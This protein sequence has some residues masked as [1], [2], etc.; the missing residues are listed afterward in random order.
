MATDDDELARTATAPASSSQPG[1]PAIPVDSTL[2]RYRIE[3]ELGAGGMGVVHAAFDPDLERRVALKVLRSDDGSGD[4]RQRLLR[5]ARAMA[6]LAHPNVVTVHEVGS[7][8]GRDFVAMELIDG[9]TLAD[10]LRGA[11]RPEDEIV[12]AFAAAARGLAAAHAAGIV[13]RD[14]KPHNVLRSRTGRIVVTDFGLARDAADVGA[15]PMAMTM[16]GTPKAKSG[17]TAS[18]SSPLSG[19]TATGSVLGTPAYMAPEQWSS[20]AV[21]P[22]TDQFAF[23]VAMWEAFTGERPFRSPTI[24][25]LKQEI[26]RGPAALDASK[27]PRR[28][29]AALIRGLDPEPKRR[30]PSMESLLAAMTKARRGPALAV[31][32]IGLAIV[33][34]AAIYVISRE[35]AAQSIA[36]A[37][38][39][40]PPPALDPDKLDLAPTGPH[41]RDL[42]ALA[43][44]LASWKIARE[45]ACAMDPAARRATLQCLDGVLARLDVIAAGVK[46]FDAKVPPVE[47][48]AYAIDP[49]ACSID[50]A[51]RLTASRAAQLREAL[52]AVMREDTSPGRPDE[53]VV[54]ELLDRVKAEPCA[55]ALTHLLAA[56]AVRMPTERQR[57]LDEAEQ[58][59]DRCAD[60]RVRA[61]TAVTVAKFA[62]GSSFLGTGIS[63]KVKLA[64]VAVDR[65]KQP[66]LV[67]EMDLL[68][69]ETA[70]R[71]DNTDEAIQRGEA[72]MA[73]FA[74]RGR[75]AAQITT[76]LTTLDHREMRSQPE[77][78]VRMKEKPI[79]WRSLAVGKLGSDHPIVNQIDGDI[80]WRRWLAGDITAAI[81]TL[82][83]VRRE[84]P[85]AR[86]RRVTGKVV[87]ETGAP[88]AGATV[89][90]AKQLV[91]GSERAAIPM[92]W[93][94]GK[95]RTATTTA[96]GDY[97][98]EASEDSLMIAQL[99]AKRSMPQP[100]ADT[101]KL[102]LEPTSRIEGR[103]DL[104][105]EPPT[106]VLVSVQDTRAPA[107]T[108]YE[109]IAPVAADGSFVVDGVPRSKLRVFA[110]LRN[111]SS[112]SLASVIVEVHQPVVKG[113]EIAVANPKR[114]VH[115]LV[116]S[117]VGAPVGNAQ[118]LVFPGLYKSTTAERMNLEL[119][120][121]SFRLARQI[122]L[123]KAPPAVVTQA[124]P[125]DMFASV[126]Q[127]PDGAASACAIGLPN[128]LS[129]PTLDA[130][131]RMNLAKLEIRCV[132]IPAGVE[133]VVVEV[134]PWP[135]LD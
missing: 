62:L 24:E 59:A 100:I 64:G 21:T 26:Q 66:D 63:A 115:V 18:T 122:E 35:P 41:G 28:L 126:Q 73:G 31:A 82:D 27:I 130:K 29:R 101:V 17:S 47:S 54:L 10:W 121:G 75:V 15:D 127:V 36:V 112:R 98:L 97:E 71:A 46:S 120:G 16:P 80:A 134:P 23:C 77:D 61:E 70:I 2:G 92:P 45:R 53:K 84:E 7:A 58:D 133:T 108:R 11:K 94:A 55:S 123:E 38:S 56:E 69:M 49:A 116:R 9:E 5:E 52:A 106:R 114:V 30:W 32:I 42:Q 102:V 109:V 43:A 19:L 117:T 25:Q 33:A 125:G 34:L 86:M 99:G 14:F 39:V 90:A 129:D 4:A 131:I 68:R 1:A 6:R 12:V 95:L 8:N 87:D 37:P 96:T 93:M 50:P 40:C 74:A 118:V 128:D 44:D 124:H 67:A 89:S 13:H 79:E 104:R 76:G 88:V 72:A 105:G 85:L 103:V 3:R 91:G 107:R 20:G 113:I 119:A 110:A 60:D 132:P 83:K 48:A 65:V 22:A 51:P 57:H 81:A 111:A 135:R 78:L